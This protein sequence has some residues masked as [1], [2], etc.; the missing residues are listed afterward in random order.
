M[1]QHP[2]PG[3]LS[4]MTTDEPDFPIHNQEG[5]TDI[6]LDEDG[7][8]YLDPGSSAVLILADEDGNPYYNS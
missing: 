2:Y 3:G 8:P 7:T 4:V 1:T 5:I 6:S